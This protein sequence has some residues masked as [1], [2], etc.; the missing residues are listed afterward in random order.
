LDDTTLTRLASYPFRDLRFMAKATAEAKELIDASPL[1]TEVGRGKLNLQSTSCILW[2]V[3]DKFAKKY[4]LKSKKRDPR[5]RAVAEPINGLST[6]LTEL[7]HQDERIPIKNVITPH[8]G[9][10]QALL[11][12]AAK[13]PEQVE[14]WG[15]K[16][17]AMLSERYRCLG[18]ENEFVDLVGSRPHS[19]AL[20]PHGS[21]SGTQ[22]LVTINAYFTMGLAVDQVEEIKAQ[23]KKES[24][25]YKQLLLAQQTKT[26]KLLLEQQEK[27]NKLV[28]EQQL[29]VVDQERKNNVQM[30]NMRT[31][32]EISVLGKRSVNLAAPRTSHPVNQVTIGNM[33]CN[34]SRWCH[35]VT[36]KK[37]NGKQK[38]LCEECLSKDKNRRV[39][40]KKRDEAPML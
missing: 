10:P 18:R 15:E 14:D 8:L 19:L 12:K 13:Y 3:L 6:F 9:M 23:M 36:R 21:A 22:A 31:L 34:N 37:V 35:N 4:K 39:G 24:K 33:H 1:G 30:A 40:K 29:R 28:V 26:D 25:K 11:M 38:Q 20:V 7:C 27:M 16:G 5:S 2:S 32:I 17:V